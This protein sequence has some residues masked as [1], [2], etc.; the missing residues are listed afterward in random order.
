MGHND[1]G[2]GKLYA[3]ATKGNDKD[4]WRD[5]NDNGNNDN[6]AKGQV[7]VNGN[8]TT[9]EVHND[10]G[11]SGNGKECQ[12]IPTMGNNGKTQGGRQIMA[13]ALTS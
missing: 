1:N 10:K 12:A 13:T 5:N 3:R 11:R 9:E 6:G 2:K 4:K 7:Q 8:K